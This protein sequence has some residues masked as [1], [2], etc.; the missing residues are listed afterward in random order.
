LILEIPDELARPMCA[1]GSDL[2]RRA[3]EALALE[4]YKA[5]RISRAQLRHLLGF[6]TRYELDGFLKAHDVWVDATVDDVR[7]DIADLTAF[8]NR[9]GQ[10]RDL[11]KS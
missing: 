6:G 4:E 2:S 1:A 7:N 5:A 8:L 3:L 9:R 10:H 11:A